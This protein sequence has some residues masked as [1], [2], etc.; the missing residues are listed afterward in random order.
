MKNILVILILSLATTSYSQSAKKMLAELENKWKTDVNGDVT[1]ERIVQ[2]PNLNKQEIYNRAL[3]YYKYHY[4]NAKSVLQ[5]TDK[6]KG[7]IIRKAMYEAHDGYSVLVCHFNVWHI[8]TIQAKDNSAEIH[9]TLTEYEQI[10]E[11]YIKPQDDDSEKIYKSLVK[12]NYPI[13]PNGGQKTMMTKAFYK[14]YKAAMVS[15]DAIEEGLKE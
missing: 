4:G 8:L 11:K 3:N 9:L 5:T 7:I 14:A 1:F 12:N 15:L 13:N 2:L 6:E 10:V